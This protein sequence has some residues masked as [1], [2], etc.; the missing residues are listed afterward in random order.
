L[1]SS[2]GLGFVAGMENMAKSWSAKLRVE[3]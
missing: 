1:S 3:I 2:R